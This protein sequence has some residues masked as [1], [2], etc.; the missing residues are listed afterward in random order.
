MSEVNGA[1]AALTDFAG[2]DAVIAEVRARAG[3]LRIGRV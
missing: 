1:H 3:G 2:L